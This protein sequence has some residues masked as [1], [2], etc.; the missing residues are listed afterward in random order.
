MALKAWPNAAR[1]TGWTKPHC[2]RRGKLLHA[3]G[4]F[5]GADSHR[6]IAAGGQMNF[7]A[8]ILAGGKSSRAWG[9]TRRG[10]KLA[11]ETL[12][13]RQIQLSPAKFW[14]GGNFYFR[15]RGSGIILEFNY[16]VYCKT[17]SG[18]AGPLAGIERALDARIITFT[19]GAGGGLARN[20][21]GIFTAA[22][23]LAV[24][25][26]VGSFQSYL[27]ASNRSPRFIQKVRIHWLNPCF[28][29]NLMRLQTSLD[30]VFNPTLPDSLNCLQ[31]RAKCFC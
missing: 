24:R 17:N 14:R 28:G 10:W 12:L 30:V 20:E 22:F 4:G 16:R 23:R 29:S 7:S 8:V 9:A 27:A 25:K 15:P 6:R 26:L 13:A 3:R 31:A 1:V 19:A 11:G 5:A 21:S 2:A 18:D